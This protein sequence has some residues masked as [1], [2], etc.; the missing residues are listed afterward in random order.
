METRVNGRGELDHVTDAPVALSPKKG[1]IDGGHVRLAVSL[2]VQSPASS[3][4]PSSSLPP[5]HHHHPLRRL[6]PPPSPLPALS[7]TLPRLAAA[8]QVSLTP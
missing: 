3:L 6:P 5:S 2:S 1:G 7:L 8:L 4:R